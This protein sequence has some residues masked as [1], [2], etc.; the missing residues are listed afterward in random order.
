LE[1]KA[2]RRYNYC[3]NPRS[4]RESDLVLHIAVGLRRNTRKGNW[5][6]IGRVPSRFG[7]KKEREHTVWRSWKE[8]IW[9]TLGMQLTYGIF[10]ISL[11]LV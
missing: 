5:H 7:R 3:L 4:F 6:P 10:T 9:G 8:D 2:T 11:F 1:E